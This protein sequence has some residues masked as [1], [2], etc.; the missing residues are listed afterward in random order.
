[1]KYF[2]YLSGTFT[3]ASAS[4]GA[5]FL[6]VILGQISG[7]VRLRSSQKSSKASVAGLMASTG[8][9]GSQ[10]PQSNAVVG[11]DDEH[12]LALVEAIDRADLDAIGVF[13]LD[14]GFIDDV[15]HAVV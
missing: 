5:G 4:G 11:V 14:A 13:A 6:R 3:N 1:M 12:V 15:G 10:T 8:H 9:S 7:H 2:A